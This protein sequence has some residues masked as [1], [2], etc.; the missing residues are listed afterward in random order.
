V[1]CPTSGTNVPSNSDSSSVPNSPST[2]SKKIKTGELTLNL[3]ASLART[4]SA[5]VIVDGI[6]GLAIFGNTS[7]IYLAHVP[8]KGGEVYSRLGSVKATTYIHGT[9]DV[10]KDSI[11]IM[12]SIVGGNLIGFKID[13]WVNG[14]TNQSALFNTRDLLNAIARCCSPLTTPPFS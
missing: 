3:R 11:K 4:M 7:E 2:S 12:V 10:I 6:V 13:A 14:K 8:D 9:K 5:P 1:N